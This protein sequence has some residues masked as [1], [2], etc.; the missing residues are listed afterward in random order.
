[1]APLEERMEASRDE[2]RSH[3]RR[4]GESEPAVERH[5]TRGKPHE[6]IHIAFHTRLV[7]EHGPEPRKALDAERTDL[8]LRQPEA[9]NGLISAQR[10]TYDRELQ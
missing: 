3:A 4:F 8:G 9:T 10:S 7:S 5:G 1:M 6:N 2:A